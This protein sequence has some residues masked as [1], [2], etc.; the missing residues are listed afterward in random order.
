[1]EICTN[2]YTT[3]IYYKFSVKLSKYLIMN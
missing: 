1:M 2:I 3:Q